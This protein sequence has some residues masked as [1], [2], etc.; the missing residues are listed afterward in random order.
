MSL[1]ERSSLESPHFDN[2]TE[3][4]ALDTAQFFEQACYEYCQQE[5]CANSSENLDVLTKTVIRVE[6]KEGDFEDIDNGMV[7]SFRP[8]QS[9]N[10]MVEKYTL[11]RKKDRDGSSFYVTLESFNTSFEPLN[12]G[13]FCKGIDPDGEAFLTDDQIDR[14]KV[15]CA[16]EQGLKSMVTSERPL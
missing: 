9:L 6:N 16:N 3:P 10:L 2:Q 13:N 5:P 7:K 12:F 15:F 8:N 11:K 14:L 4:S 1:T